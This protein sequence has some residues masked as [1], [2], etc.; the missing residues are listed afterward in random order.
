MCASEMHQIF[1]THMS[2]ALSR[3]SAPQHFKLNDA[4]K[5]WNRII[6]GI[7]TLYYALNMIVVTASN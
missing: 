4:L 2:P 7:A 6:P 5:I 1:M 3:S